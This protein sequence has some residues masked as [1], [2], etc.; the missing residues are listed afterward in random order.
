MINHH[1]IFNNLD[2]KELRRRKFVWEKL[3]D[4]GRPVIT[5]SASYTGQAGG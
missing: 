3:I 1:Y 4:N 2:W 5:L